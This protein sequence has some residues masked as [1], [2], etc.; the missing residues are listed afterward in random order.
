[1]T[2]DGKPLTAATADF[3]I[4]AKPHV[5]AKATGYAAYD[6]VVT[7]SKDDTIEI[8]LKKAAAPAGDQAPK[9]PHKKKVDL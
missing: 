2:I 1:M 9:P 7:V 4:G 5:Q 3:D 6:Q 8:T